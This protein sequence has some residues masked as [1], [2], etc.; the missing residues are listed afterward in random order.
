VDVYQLSYFPAVCAKNDTPTDATA[1]WLLFYL[2][3]A[4]ERRLRIPPNTDAIDIE[5][6]PKFRILWKTLIDQFQEQKLLDY[7]DDTTI[8]DLEVDF[9]NAMF[10]SP[11]DSFDPDA[12]CH[13]PWFEKCCGEKRTVSDLKKHGDFDDV[14]LK[15]MPLKTINY[16]DPGTTD[17]T[18][19]PAPMNVKVA[20]VD[21]DTVA[22]GLLLP[23]V[24]P[25][26]SA[27]GK[28]GTPIQPPQPQPS[29]ML[30][31]FLPVMVLLK[32]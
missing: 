15:M 27:G 19:I 9:W 29:N 20:Q 13:S 28:G 14:Y 25:Q 6:D 2:Y 1:E 31:Q 4:D 18:Q 22:L 17:D 7:T 16:P 8:D 24:Y 12:Y 11:N 30:E 3:H 23:A 10:T 32:V 26:F 5:T 21:L